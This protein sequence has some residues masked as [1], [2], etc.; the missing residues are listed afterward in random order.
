MDVFDA[1]RESDTVASDEAVTDSE[2]DEELLQRRQMQ[3]EYI[4]GDM[5]AEPSFH[6]TLTPLM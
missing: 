6:P 2:N 1:E 5:F 3:K 4:A